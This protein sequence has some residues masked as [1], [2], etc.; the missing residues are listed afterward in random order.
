[1]P[2]N[3]PSK[4][5]LDRAFQ[6]AYAQLNDAQKRAVEL[7]EGPVLVVAGPGTGKTQI[8]ALR[9]GNILNQTDVQPG[10]IL[11]LTY[12]D[13]G[14]IAMRKRLLKFIGPEAYKVQVH[15]FH[16]FCN[17]VIQDNQEV[18]SD[19]ATLH[20]ISDLEKAQMF[21]ELIDQFSYEHP[22]RR[23]KGQ[24]Y[25]EGKRLDHLFSLMKRE[26]W[27]PDFLLDQI[28]KEFLIVESDPS[29]FYKRNGNNYKV[30]DPNKNYSKKINGLNLLKS[31]VQAFT[32]FQ[33]MLH[34]K[35]RYDFDDMIH[36]VLNAFQKDEA[37]LANY[38]E[39]FL[40]VLVDEYQ[41]TNGSQN[42]IIEL[43]V[44]YWEQPNLFVV[45]DDDQAIFRFQGASISNLKNL[46]QKYDPS[47]IV[48]TQNYRSTQ[49]I[50]NASM[51]LIE[52][53]AD[54]IT[55]EIPGTEKKLH[56]NNAAIHPPPA[57]AEYL[58]VAQEEAGIFTAIKKLHDTSVDLKEVAVIY[59][60]HSQASNLIKALSQI[61]IPVDVKQRTNILDEPIIRNIEKIFSF[62]QGEFVNP[63]NN[64]ALL[65][66]L[67]HYRFFDLPPL[68]VAKLSSY[69][70]ADV[71]NRMSL[72]HASKD[73]DI[74]T[75]LKLSDVDAFIRFNE[76]IDGWLLELPHVS[77]QVLFEKILKKGHFFREIMSN[78][79]RTYLMQVV[80]T[81]FNYIKDESNR[82]PELDIAHLL[83]TVRDMREIGLRLDMQSVMRAKEGV[84]FMTAHGA[85]GL[86]F[87]HV[88]ILGANKNNWDSI[89]G[90]R[91]GYTLPSTIV[92]PSKETDLEDE[93]RLFYVAMTRA[94]NRL[95]ISYVAENI[96][97]MPAEPSQFIAELMSATE[98]ESIEKSVLEEET[99]EYYTHLLGS[100]DQRLPLLDH[101][102]IDK[103]LDKF[104]LSPT[105]L[106]KYLTCPRSFYFENILRVPLANSPYLGFG[107]AVHF[108]LQKLI[109]DHGKGMAMSE[110][111]LL[112]LYRHSMVYFQSHFSPKEYEN[113]I[114]HGEYILPQYLEK[115]L[116]E[117]QS[118]D[119]LIS[120]KNIS[121][122]HPQRCPHQ[123]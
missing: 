29:N 16:S 58:N 91:N 120:E 115:S 116:P 37:L 86:E 44:D 40:Y 17:Q 92:D 112:D 25:F 3:K 22:L 18:F 118:S 1:M 99:V 96:N 95:Q 62:L 75:S 52:F 55:D 85:K 84:R 4:S 15:T 69:C 5:H 60:K 6:Q 105:A 21:K 117:W 113:Y 41:D 123:R 48:L 51:A 12:T 11:C 30:G 63:G 65:F 10:N 98:L 8:L 36:W 31:A 80:A 23:L 43:L 94:R 73:L 111:R 100:K 45:G 93:R 81:F 78:Q 33:N 101:S 102:L 110:E 82:N 74:L 108:A 61:G 97:G 83:N 19:L 39:R 121:H 76:I 35:G 49:S 114:K 109:E 14:A 68:D 47:L 87:D 32:P 50:L 9:I 53:N 54:R 79:H 2:E 28:E 34:E 70:W 57:V 24:L 71:R 64:D 107:N 122:V 77:L 38:Q 119:L 104:Q 90:R 66:E 26:S 103:V 42:K 56:A 46:F 106:N 20:H 7:I 27:T 89:F 59:R 67:M 13:A 88:F 72:R